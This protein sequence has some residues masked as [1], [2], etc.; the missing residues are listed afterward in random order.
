MTMTT[1]VLSKIPAQLKDE[2][3]MFCKVRRGQKS[4]FEHDWPRRP[5]KFSQIQAW[6]KQG[7]NYG[8]QGGHGGLI[9]IDAD[10]PMIA[11]RVEKNFP[12]TF[13]V[14]TPGHGFHY[15]FFCDG[16]NKKI[17]FDNEHVSLDENGKKLHFGEIISHGSQAVGPGSIHPDTGTEY[18]VHRDLPIA[19]I[20]AELVFSVFA[21]L[22]KDKHKPS[23]QMASDTNNNSNQGYCPSQL[24]IDISHVI[25]RYGL[26]T[27][28]SSGQLTCP[29]P[30]HG[31]ENGANLVIHPQKNVWH[32]FRCESGGD[33]LLLI[34]VLERIISCDQA[35]PGVL[36][37]D[38]FTQTL[39]LAKQK[40]GLKPSLSA[41]KSLSTLENRNPLSSDAESVGTESQTESSI[42]DFSGFFNDDWNSRVFVARHGSNLKNCDNLGGW[43]IWNGKVWELDEQH[44]VIRM[45]RDTVDSFNDLAN[46][47]T[48]ED[49]RDIFFKHIKQSGNEAKLKA[50]TSLARSFEGMSVKS[51]AFD[52]EPYLLN[53]QNGV[54]DLKSGELKPYSRELLSTKLCVARYDPLAECPHWMEFLTTVFR[55]DEELIR[56]VQKVVG[57]VL[58]GDVSYQMFFILHGSGANGKSTFVDTIYKLLGSYASI[59]PTTTLIEKRGNEIPND[60]ARLKGA[61]FVI[62]SELERSKTLDESLIKQLTSLEPIVARFL[63]R[64]FFEFRPTAKV[65]LSTNYKPTVKGTDD[66]IWRRIKLIPFD[67]KFEG[68]AKIEK[69][70]EKYL[71]PELSGILRWAVEGFRKLQ[72]E[73]FREPQIVRTATDQ[74]QASEDIIGSFLKESCVLQPHCMVAASELYDQYCKNSEVKIRRKDF[75][76]YLIRRG[77]ARERGTSGRL[78]GVQYWLGIGI[79]DLLHNDEGLADERPF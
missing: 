64:E 59:T 43:H 55:S 25:S 33:A 1:N 28:N 46:A 76:D 42:D 18:E 9:I 56:F 53:C 75:N 14:R 31:S 57:Y 77:Y 44:N 5:Y 65:F 50:M 7:F 35:Q 71:F 47:M 26:K 37:G 4:P 63:H 58:T 68:D 22:I 8:V 69:Y 2:R 72:E 29:H 45:A 20:E 66:G 74:Y 19:H 36:R 51:S 48:D 13:T 78:K 11:E 23:T 41:R 30:I 79:K 10:L 24:T 52:A 67:H 61:R 49:R 60:I 73:G 34:A 54:L 3:I 38:L 17:V 62:A 21:D 12:Q 6:I 32:C 27:R 39:A 70:A 40:Y 16:I 15:Y